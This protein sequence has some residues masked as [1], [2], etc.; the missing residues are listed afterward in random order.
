M[1]LLEHL[2]RQISGLSPSHLPSLHFVVAYSAGI[3][4][5]VLLH[6][7]WKLQQVK[8][9]PFTLSAIYIHH[10]LSENADLWQQHCADVC[11]G[12]NV[13]FASA[14]VTLDLSNGKG[15]EAQARDARY[16][17]LVEMAPTDSI[18]MLAQHQDDQLETVLLQLKRGAGPKG[19]SGMDTYF[20]SAKP[21][22]SQ[23]GRASCR[24]RV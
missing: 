11:A 9:T 21:G 16:A 20:T 4:S 5:H 1:S 18:V 22:A 17:K 7:L 23:I 2:E 12:L 13:E 3:D 10:G 15:I 14:K 24:E 6:A 19:L 8:K